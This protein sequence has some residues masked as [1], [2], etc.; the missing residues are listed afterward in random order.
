M[1]LEAG[2]SDRGHARGD[3]RVGGEDV[4]QGPC[5]ALY[6]DDP[7][8]QRRSDIRH[9]QIRT[10]ARD[11]RPDLR[12]DHLPSHESSKFGPVTSAR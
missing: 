12:P 9:R 3:V 8:E 11:A 2:D 7:R 1:S 6:A 5:S 4:E 10:D